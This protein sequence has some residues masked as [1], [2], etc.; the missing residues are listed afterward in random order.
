M[1]SSVDLDKL[2]MDI[3]RKS[4]P[5]YKDLKGSYQFPGYQL[6]IYHVQGDPF[7][8]PS[9][10]GIQVKKEQAGFPEEYYNIDYR[11]IALQ[12]YLERQFG[13]AVME[14]MFKAKG[15]GKSGLISVSRCGQEVLERTAF[16]IDSGSLLARFEAGFPA[17]GRTINSYELR[18]ILFDYIPKAVE[19][20]MYYK[21]LDAEETRRKIELSEDQHF[22]REELEKRKL[23]AFIANGAVLPRESGVSQKPMKNAVKFQSPASMEIELELPYK[24][25]IKGMGIPEGITLVAGG[26]Y[27][28]KST[29]LKALEQGIYQHIEGDGREYVITSGTAAKIRAE[30]GRAVS[31]VN[32]S[33]FISDLPNKKNTTDFSTEDASGS[34]SQAANVAEALQAGAKV[35]LI[36]EDTCATNFMVCDSLMQE[37]VSGEHEPI[38]PFTLQAR[39]LYEEHGI[40]VIIVAGSSGSYFYIAD[41]I[42]QMDNYH[43][44]D[45]TDKVHKILEGRESKYYRQDI[46][47]S[48]SVLFDKKKRIL[49]VKKMDK[50]R[51]QVK[52]K[53]FG[54]N[55][56]SIGKETVDLRYLEQ[57][58]DSEQTT[59]LAYCL[60][61]LA[62]QMETREMDAAAAVDRLWGQL[63]EK[64]LKSLCKDTYL[65]VSM[66]QVRKQDIFACLDR[67]RGII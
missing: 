58:L 1:K 31:H 29:L 9:K 26:G 5:A 57:I 32:I 61:E 6:D 17:N 49:K 52:I 53:Q 7:A 51:G 39:K 37:V 43:A 56:F 46:P 19:K 64:G 16:E 28:G 15:S 63:Q 35:L 34:T 42:L 62:E 30:D 66:A 8:A 48:A 65:P 27:H 55:S 23:V 10:L 13:K 41:K 11:R 24:G 47:V 54:R 50:K 12:D 22:I 59:T 44:Y 18:K 45:I 33:P 67:Y 36:D 21:N 40:S 4:Y 3:N 25:K 20:S 38:T 60:K 2:L 14:Y